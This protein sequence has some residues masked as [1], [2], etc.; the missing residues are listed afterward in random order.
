MAAGLLW[1]FLRN[2]EW[3]V[4]IDGLRSVGW[5]LLGG[6]IVAR[7][8]SL[9]V[10]SVRWQ[11]LLAPVRPVPLGPVVTAMMMGMAVSALVSMQAAEIA[12]PYLLSKRVDLSFSATVAT[13]AVEWLL[14]LLSVLTLFIPARGLVSGG[15]SVGRSDVSIAVVLL[16]VVSVASLVALRWVPRGL[17]EVRGWI[18]NSVMVPQRLRRK[19][20]ENVEQFVV[21]L[22]ILESPKGLVAVASCS[23]LA[24]FLVAVSAW[25]ALLAFGLS[26][27]FLSGFVILGLIT[28]GGLIPTPG[29]IGGFHAVCQFGL[30]AWLGLDPAQTVAPV[31]GLHAVLY[32]P[33]AAIGA[34]C[35]FWTRS[36]SQRK[37][38]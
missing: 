29:A 19:T 18:D 21:G 22:R 23:L 27:S 25:L 17:G 20:A 24:S 14:D 37:P 16:V 36:E 4:L 12:R 2:A 26:V 28:I 30:V 35:F 8:A 13:V 7:L 3:R 31:I 15:A 5:L 11:A 34:L 10:S 6:A 38:A 9:I 32:A 1:L 33:G